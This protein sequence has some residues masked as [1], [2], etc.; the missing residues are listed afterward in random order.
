MG[1]GR[2]AASGHARVYRLGRDLELRQRHLLNATL[3][4]YD[5]NGVASVGDCL[6]FPPN[7][8][9]Q[10]DLTS[11]ETLVAKLPPTNGTTGPVNEYASLAL[12]VTCE[13]LQI[14]S[15]NSTAPTPTDTY[16]LVPPANLSC[17]D[18]QVQVGKLA[19]PPSRITTTT[20]RGVGVPVS[21]YKSYGVIRTRTRRSATRPASQGLYCGKPSSY[22][23]GAGSIW[24]ASARS[25][26]EGCTTRRARPTS[27]TLAA[28][29]A[30]LDG[31]A[32][33]TDI[34]VSCHCLPLPEGL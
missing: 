19:T 4:D 25:S 2:S 26:G 9:K 21:S 8:A 30:R 16:S 27:T 3:I 6:Q 1:R 22:G 34:G 32:G 12:N 18:N 13:G 7:I 24:A 15:I 5:K 10:I 17:G 29:S 28:A 23:R 31:P 20:G 14:V 33:T 11:S